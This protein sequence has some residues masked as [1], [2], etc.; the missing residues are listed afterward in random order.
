MPARG[1]ENGFRGACRDLF[2]AE[3]AVGGIGWLNSSTGFVNWQATALAT[4][5]QTKVAGTSRMHEMRNNLCVM[6]NTP[7]R[8]GPWGTNVTLIDIPKVTANMEGRTIVC[9]G[10]IDPLINPTLGCL[11]VCR[12]E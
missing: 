8:L 1:L 2:R 3:F 7:L 4:E 11:P 9:N 6:E 5:C 12:W 10:R